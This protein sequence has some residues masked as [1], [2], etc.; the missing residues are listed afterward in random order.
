ME[1]RHLR[2]LLAIADEGHFTRAAQRLHVSQPALSQQI[3]QLEDGLG[4]TLLDRAGRRV[5][6]TAAGEIVVHHAR[7][8]LNEM[9]EAQVALQELAGLQRGALAIGTVQTVNAYLMPQ[10]VAQFANAYPAIHVRIE[11]LSADAIE[12]GLQQGTLQLGIGFVPSATADIEAEPLFDEELVLIVPQEHPFAERAVVDTR[13]VNGLPLVLLSSAFCTRRLWDSCAREAAIQTP[14]A[15]RDEHDRGCSSVGASHTRSY[16][17]AV[18]GTG[19]RARA[20]VGR[21]TPA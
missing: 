9:N 16:D 7:R 18:V 11:E 20:R 2:Y 21:H 13:E 1:L 5:R 19:K 17:S 3:R 4:A 14:R 10:V 6:L 15:G 12:Q 8:M